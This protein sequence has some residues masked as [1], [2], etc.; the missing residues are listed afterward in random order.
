MADRLLLADGSSRLLLADGSS[1]L[2]LANQSV[3]VVADVHGCVTV[4]VSYAKGSASAA[5]TF[6]AVVGSVTVSVEDC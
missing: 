6:P 5:V 3:A 4:G 2:L 1:F